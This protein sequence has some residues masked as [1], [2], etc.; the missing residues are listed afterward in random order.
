M[1]QAPGHQGCTR[2]ARTHRRDAGDPRG[3][4]G[5]SEQD[6]EHPIGKVAQHDQPADG[7]SSEINAAERADRV[8]IELRAGLGPQDVKC[9]FVGLR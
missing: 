9:R 4:G 1:S 6:R 7:A 2:E 3:A 8:G 5:A